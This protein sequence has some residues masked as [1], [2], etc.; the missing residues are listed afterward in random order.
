MAILTFIHYVLLV[1]VVK[2]H[3][4][5]S[6]FHNIKILKSHF[7][8]FL[9]WW[10]DDTVIEVVFFS[11]WIIKSIINFTWW[12]IGPLLR[13]IYLLRLLIQIP[14]SCCLV[15]DEPF[16]KTWVSATKIKF[17]QKIGTFLKEQ[18]TYQEISE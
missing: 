7:R 4:F 15:T 16:V 3:P 18:K 5:F 17:W 1:Y 10:I 11:L 2:W 12:M 13:L 6:Q 8:Q 9:R 14:N